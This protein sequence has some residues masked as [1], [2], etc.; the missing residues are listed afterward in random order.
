MSKEDPTIQEI[1][2]TIPDDVKKQVY[3]FIGDKEFTE[4]ERNDFFMRRSFLSHDQRLV[5]HLLIGLSIKDEE[6]YSTDKLK[7]AVHKGCKAVGDLSY[8]V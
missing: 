7:R 6:D 1:W 2:D 3:K 8:I 4:K 5:I